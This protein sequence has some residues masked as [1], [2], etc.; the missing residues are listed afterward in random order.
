[1]IISLL[2]DLQQEQDK[3]SEL[4]IGEMQDK[5]QERALLVCEKTNTLIDL[6]MKPGSHEQRKCRCKCKRKK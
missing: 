6:S 3:E 2:A 5:V 1:V 4:V